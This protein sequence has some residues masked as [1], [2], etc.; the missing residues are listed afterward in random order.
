M[1]KCPVCSAKNPNDEVYCISCDYEFPDDDRESSGKRSAKLVRFLGAGAVLLIL[2]CIVVFAV[3]G[4]FSPRKRLADAIS[5]SCTAVAERVSV[6]DGIAGFAHRIDE[7]DK[8]GKYTMEIGLASA[9]QNISWSMD[10]D[11][12]QKLVSGELVYQNAIAESP[13]HAAVYMDD[14]DVRIAA[15]EF[16]DD[17]YGFDMKDFSEK[18]EES[19]LRKILGLPSAKKLELDIYKPIKWTNVLKL[20]VGDSWTAFADTITVEEFSEREIMLG[21]ESVACVVYKVAWDAAAANK[22]LK[23]LSE[24][25]ILSLPVELLGLLPDW[26]PDCRCYVDSEGNW[27]GGDM[28]LGG[29]KYILLLEG[30]ENPWDSVTLEVQPMTGENRKYTGG[31]SVQ[32]DKLKLYLGNESEVFLNVN[33]D[34][35]TGVFSVD[36]W[37]GTILG[38]TIRSENE[39]AYLMLSSYLSGNGYIAVDL[40]VSPLSHQVATLSDKYV[41]L[42]DMGLRKWERMIIELKNHL[43]IELE[44]PG[45]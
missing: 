42:L 6:M 7:A 43:G 19:V 12:R 14:Q 27:V 37:T 22:L 8:E 35:V 28:I 29:N 21:G 16:V 34:D 31:L 36:T 17:I 25:G 9:D 41:D 1:K 2:C 13:V 39:E 20:H 18:Y 4:H 10:Y 24:G 44:I 3:I 33:Y 26:E 38:G 45:L 32:S 11:R 5:N 30:K 23:S 15:P 40:K